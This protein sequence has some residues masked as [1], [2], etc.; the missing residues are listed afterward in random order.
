MSPSGFSLAGRKDFCTV[1]AWYNTQRKHKP[2]EIC[3]PTAKISKL[4]HK[5]VGPQVYNKDKKS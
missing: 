5:D 2:E 3:F 4:E 1:Q